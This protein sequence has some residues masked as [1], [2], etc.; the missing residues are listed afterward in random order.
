[1]KRIDLR[2]VCNVALF[3]LVVIITAAIF[4][5]N[6]FYSATISYDTYEAVTITVSWQRGLWFCLLGV[7]ALLLAAGLYRVK[8]W[9]NVDLLFLYFSI[10]YLL[11]GLL[12]IN[13]VD[14]NLRSDSLMVYDAADKFVKGSLQYFERGKYLHSYPHQTGLMLYNSVFRFLGLNAGGIFTVNLVFVIAINYV[15]LKIAHLLF[16]SKK[17][18][19]VTV[20]LSFAFLPQFFFILFAYGLIP[21]LIFMSLAFYFALRLVKTNNIICLIPLCLCGAIAVLIRKNY[22]IGIVAIAIYLVLAKDVKLLKRLAAL[23]AV[24]VFGFVPMKLLLGAFEAKTGND[25]DN[26]VPTV[27]WIAMGTD[28]ENRDRA[29]G[30][31]NGFNYYTYIYQGYDSEKT[32]KIGKEKLEENI[33]KI[34]ADPEAAIKFFSEKNISIWCE[35]TYQ[36]VWSGPLAVCGQYAHTD[37]LRSLYCG[38]EPEEKIAYFDELITQLIWLFA[39]VYLVFC[40]K[41]QDGWQLMFLYM[42]GGILFHTIWEGKSQYIYPYVFCLIPFAAYSFGVC[43]EKTVKLMGRFKS[44]MTEYITNQKNKTAEE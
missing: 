5:I 36:S 25:L 33:E 9:L 41:K 26:G 16:N 12:L 4:G 22:V 34:K 18:D 14:W 19:L 3:A 6:F 23:I 32:E 39:L 17:T 20:A 2:K 10:I 21:G 40:R 42:T 1:M 43:T 27:M 24:L 38:G 30:W 13:N 37:Y 29:P 11:L 44:K 35:N 7:L 31:Y 15:W 28:L 8:K